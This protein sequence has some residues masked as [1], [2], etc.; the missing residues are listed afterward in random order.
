MNDQASVRSFDS[1]QRVR[2][3]LLAFANRSTD[4]L[5]ELNREIRRV[6]DWVEHDRPG[7][8]KICVRQ[9][10]DNVTEAKG[11]LHR[12]LMYPIND[13]QPSC[14]EE[15]AGLKKAEAALDYARGKQER[16]RHWVQLLRHELH[17]YEGG[18]T[19]LKEYVEVDVPQGAARLGRTL[20]A[21]E[22]YAATSLPTS[23][24][25]A[26]TTSTASKTTELGDQ[27]KGEGSVESTDST[28]NSP[29]TEDSDETL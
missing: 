12:C 7:H 26:K 14:S 19:Q 28:S 4:G 15:R 13:E 11:A 3:E 10:Y 1:I 21:L 2:E 22:Q 18:I 20:A 9:A 6:I 25:A 5:T 23:S 27:A 16:V 29:T 8:W 17:E 24:A